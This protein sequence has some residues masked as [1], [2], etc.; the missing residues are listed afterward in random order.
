MIVCQAVPVT[1]GVPVAALLNEIVLIKHVLLFTVKVASIV[2]LEIVKSGK[3]PIGMLYR[4][5]VL[6]DVEI[7]S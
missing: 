1:D 2:A 7:T 3:L 5:S 6:L 4:M